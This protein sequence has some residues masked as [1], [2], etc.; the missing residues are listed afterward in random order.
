[1]NRE[2]GKG[3]RRFGL[4]TTNSLRQIFNRRV[5]EPHLSD[6]K[7]PLSLLF[8]IPDHP[9]VDTQFG[10]AVRIAMTVGSAGNRLGQLLTIAMESKEKSEAEGRQVTFDHQPGIIFANLRIGA[11]L[12]SCKP[13]QSNSELTFMGIIRVGAGFVVS[14]NEMVALGYDLTNRPSVIRRYMNGRELVAGQ[15]N[16]L[17]IRLIPL[18]PV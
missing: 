13:L 14:P 7:K 12:N 10:A 11:D 15:S 5:L 2:K 16:R 18:A 17:V 1:M 9:W 8:A 3:T 6:P 4:I